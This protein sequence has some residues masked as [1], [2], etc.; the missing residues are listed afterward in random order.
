MQR[1][2][3]YK[4]KKQRLV[5]FFYKRTSS[6]DGLY[7]YC[8][9]CKQNDD[10]IYCENNR[11]KVLENKKLYYLN[12]KSRISEQRKE[13]QQRT[14]EQRRKY[15]RLYEKQRKQKDPLYKLIQNYKNRVCK[16]LKGVG[17]K[18]Q[19]T[20]KLLGCSI[21]EFCTHIENQFSKG[22]T[23]ENQG[24][25]HVDHIIPLSSATTIKEKEKLF[26]YSNCQPLWAKDNL[27]KGDKIFS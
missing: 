3:C 13:Y 6:A 9:S 12:N 18:S 2:R 17:I 11:D 21:D 24:K 20:I 5:K 19:S 16:A 14:I 4:C 15:K 10:K 8:K 23:W 27:S 26:H 1:K 25:W 7:S 22:M